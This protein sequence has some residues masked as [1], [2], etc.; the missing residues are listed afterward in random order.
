[1]AHP[2]RVLK[3][4]DELVKGVQQVWHILQLLGV[5]R[6]RGQRIRHLCVESA[7]LTPG[8]P[9]VDTRNH[10]ASQNSQLSEHTPQAWRRIGRLTFWGRACTSSGRSCTSSDVPF[11]KVST[12]KSRQGTTVWTN[13]NVM[14]V[15]RL[16]HRDR[17]HCARS[18]I[19][20]GY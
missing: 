15:Q 12:C 10:A 5:E 9:S 6:L 13:W 7:L 14:T 20:L 18:T 19:P 1:M 3:V 17:Q 16:V 4:A 2:L 11:T 8:K